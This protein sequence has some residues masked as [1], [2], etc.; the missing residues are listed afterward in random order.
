[1][2]DT[3]NAAPCELGDC[4]AALDE[5]GFAPE[6]E[7]SLGHAAH[8]LARLGAN[9]NF[10]GD[11]VLEELKARHRDDAQAANA[12]GPQVVMLAR[13][14]GD[15]F[16]RANIWPSRQEHMFRASGEDCFVYGLPH[17]HNFSFLTHGYF[18][19]GYWSDYYEFEYEDVEGWSGEPVDLRFTGR[20]RLEPG[21]VM[22]YRAHL[23]VHRQLPPDALSVS[24][25]IMEARPGLSWFDQYCFDVEQGTVAR[26]ANPASSEVFLRLAVGLGDAEALDLA[27]HFGR[28][29]PSDRMRLAAWDAWAGQAM[30]VQVRDALWREAERSGS[31]LVAKEARNRRAE[32]A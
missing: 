5:A 27:E 32:L 23:D 20:K 12:Y 22:L 30:D 6:D 13:P 15:Y 25:N 19:P 2:I 14:G 10:L 31:L 24:L 1:M 18:G 11:I 4:V 28:F 8:W 29:H 16:M 9:S 3:P 26:I 7:G 17:D 21:K